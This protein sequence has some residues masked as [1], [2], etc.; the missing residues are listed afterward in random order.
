MRQPD[1]RVNLTVH[2]GCSMAQARKFLEQL[3]TPDS[4]LRKR[5]EDP[6]QR[7]QA[8]GDFH[9]HV[10]GGELPREAVLPPAEK[11]R[12]IVADLDETSAVGYGYLMLAFG[13]AMPLVAVDDREAHPAG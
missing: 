5:L 2:L 9:F 12:E 4:E 10:I 8:L 7:L 6:E 1:D 3:A 13:F 11:I